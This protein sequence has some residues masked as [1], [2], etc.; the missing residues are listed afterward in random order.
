MS[1]RQSCRSDAFTCHATTEKRNGHGGNGAAKLNRPREG[2]ARETPLERGTPTILY[3]EV[4]APKKPVRDLERHTQTSARGSQRK[5]RRRGDGQPETATA[6]GNNCS[7]GIGAVD[8]Q[9]LRLRP[10]S[11]NTRDLQA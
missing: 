5:R 7:N 1:R 11:D 3:P 8:R 9:G 6:S 2:F 10:D 4:T